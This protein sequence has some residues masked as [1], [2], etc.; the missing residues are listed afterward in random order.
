MKWT[1]TTIINNVSGATLNY[2]FGLKSELWKREKKYKTYSLKT[3]NQPT[4]TMFQLDSTALFYIP[5]TLPGS[6]METLPDHFLGADP[7]QA[8]DN[9][10]GPVL[11]QAIAQNLE[12]TAHLLQIL[13]PVG[14]PCHSISQQHRLPRHYYWNTPDF[15]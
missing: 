5:L 1:N 8:P 11:N 4:Q 10:L 13:T 12:A 2:I 3:K 7:N 15:W 14:I 6:S 9:W